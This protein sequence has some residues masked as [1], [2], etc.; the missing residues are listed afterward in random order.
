VVI[1][2]RIARQHGGDL[3]FDSRPGGGTTATLL[4]PAPIEERA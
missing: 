1:A 2:R 4:L 3:R